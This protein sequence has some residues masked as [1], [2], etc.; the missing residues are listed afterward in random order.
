M[1]TPTREKFRALMP[2]TRR[3]AY[4][5]HAA[6]GPL[7]EP[8]RAAVAE[9]LAQA[10]EMGDAVWPEW[11]RRVELAR[12]QAAAM[13]GAGTDE[14]ALVPNTTA[15]INYIAQGFPWQAGDNVVTLANEFATTV[16]IK[17]AIKN[18]RGDYLRV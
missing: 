16:E 8:T 11:N 12:T 10:A 6:V 1:L 7:P 13:I 14:I 17:K 4:F 2:I 18:W 3:F 15:G 5:D 9:W